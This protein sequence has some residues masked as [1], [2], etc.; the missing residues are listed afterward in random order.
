ME[1]IPRG[2]ALNVQADT[3]YGR[4][5]DEDNKKRSANCSNFA[6]AGDGQAGFSCKLRP[7]FLV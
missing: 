6:H 5:F 2:A 4:T 1:T 7:G 3:Q